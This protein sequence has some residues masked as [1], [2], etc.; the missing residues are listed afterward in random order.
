[1][2]VALGAAEELEKEGISAEVIDLR[3]IRPLDWMTIL[4]SVKKQTDLSLLKSNG[5]SL[6]CHQK[7]PTKFKKKVL[8]I[9]M[10]RSEES[11]LLMHPCTTHPI[12]LLHIF[13]MLQE[14]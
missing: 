3:T 14:L 6:L 11:R 2:K 12:W 13:Q 1:M 4:E 5:R 9:W 7:L 10:R 8:I